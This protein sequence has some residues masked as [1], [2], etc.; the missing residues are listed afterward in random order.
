MRRTY[1]VEIGDGVM[2]W[3]RDCPGFDQRMVTTLGEDE[4]EANAELA[5]TPGEWQHE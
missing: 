4:M 3:W 1:N 2:T 5:Q